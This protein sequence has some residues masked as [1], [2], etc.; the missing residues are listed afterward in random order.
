MDYKQALTAQLSKKDKPRSIDHAQL[1]QNTFHAKSEEE[2]IITFLRSKQSRPKEVIQP[3]DTQ[4]V[5]KEIN[6]QWTRGN[7]YTSKTDIALLIDTPHARQWLL[8]RCQKD[9]EF[10]EVLQDLISF[11]TNNE[12]T[13]V[14]KL[15]A[16]T[17][18]DKCGNS[19][20]VRYEHPTIKPF[21]FTDITYNNPEMLSM[22]LAAGSN[23][24]GQDELGNTPL[25]HACMHKNSSATRV[26]LFYGA[27]TAYANSCGETP[28]HIAC[29]SGDYESVAALLEYHADANAKNPKSWQLETPLLCALTSCQTNPNKEQFFLIIQKLISKSTQPKRADYSQLN[30]QGISA[31]DI[32]RRLP[33]N[34]EIYRKLKDLIPAYDTL[35]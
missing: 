1:K 26:L 22:V 32:V 11:I 35:T 15:L 34:H 23:P 12:T 3:L 7:G 24:D 9:K 10:L 6:E 19:F 20:L 25:H 2:E 18:A 17:A 4:A 31:Q 16:W 29:T 28:L 13:K 14:K 5:N 30:Y 21:S 8:N 27:K 33:D